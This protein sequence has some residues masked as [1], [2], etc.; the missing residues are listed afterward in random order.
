MRRHRRSGSALIP[1]TPHNMGCY[2]W[3]QGENYKAE[4]SQGLKESWF[5]SGQTLVVQRSVPGHNN[6]IFL[7]TH[8]I[9][10]PL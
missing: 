2:S 1:R 4:I 10:I 9:S 5:T 3:L 8:L 7:N 6:E